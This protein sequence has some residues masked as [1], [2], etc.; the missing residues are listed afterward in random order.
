MTRQRYKMLNFDINTTDTQKQQLYHGDIILAHSKPII[1][2]TLHLTVAISTKSQPTPIL[3]SSSLAV[4]VFNP[5]SLMHLPIRHN[6]F[7]LYFFFIHFFLSRKVIYD[8]YKE[9]THRIMTV[10]VWSLLFRSLTPNQLFMLTRKS[11]V[12]IYL[13]F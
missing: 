12:I 7:N 6:D 10:P 3:L 9:I 13:A 5:R 11:R 2:L 4:R 8:I 1:C